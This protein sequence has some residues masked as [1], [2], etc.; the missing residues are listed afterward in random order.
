M[1]NLF[2][3]FTI[4]FGVFT[5]CGAGYVLSK[6]GTVNAGYACVPMVFSLL[7]FKLYQSKR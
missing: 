4:V 7:F 3:L 2:L 1:K 6:N 5:F